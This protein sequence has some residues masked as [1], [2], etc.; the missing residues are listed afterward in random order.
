MK[1]NSE[2]PRKR[3]YFVSM[4]SIAESISSGLLSP[5]RFCEI[6]IFGVIGGKSGVVRGWFF[7]Q[8]IV[9][10]VTAKVRK[11]TIRWHVS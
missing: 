2:N 10:I 1:I 3:L 9:S 4:E 11:V 7:V 6:P 5:D 8:K